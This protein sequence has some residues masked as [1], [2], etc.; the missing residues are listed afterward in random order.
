MLTVFH[1]HKQAVPLPSPSYHPGGKEIAKGDEEEAAGELKEEIDKSLKKVTGEE[2]LERFVHERGKGS[3]T[4]EESSNKESGGAGDGPYS[5]EEKREDSDEEG[6]A[7]VDQEG[8]VRK[9][10]ACQ[11]CDKKGDAVSGKGAQGAAGSDEKW[12]YIRWHDTDLSNNEINEIL[13]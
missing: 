5:G 1:T 4:T 8:A 13:F 12:K 10:W 2:K 3:H 7:A 6:T 11:F 9:E